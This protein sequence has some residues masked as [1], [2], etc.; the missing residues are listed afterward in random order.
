[1]MQKTNKPQVLQVALKIPFAPHLDYSLPNHLAL[2]P[3]G[4]RVLVGLG[5]NKIMVGV[6][7]SHSHESSFSSLKPIDDILDD[8]PLFNETGLKLLQQAATY[9]QTT[10]GEMIFTA[11][12]AWFKKTTNQ[13]I[14]MQKWWQAKQSLT[15]AKVLLKSAPKQLEVYQYLKLHGPLTSKSLS[16]ISAS[17]SQVC[18][19]LEAKNLASSTEL[20][21]IDNHSAIDPGYSLTTDQQ[22]ALTQ[23]SNHVNKFKVMLLDGITGSGKTELYIR[24]IQQLLQ[25]QK[26]ALVLVPEIGLTPQLF[27]EVSQRINGQMA[28]LH[29][30]LTDAAR[31]RVWHHCRTGMVDVVVATRSGIFTPFKN[32]GAILIDEEHDLS[33]KQQDGGIRYSARDLAVLRG[34]IEHIPVVLGSATPSFE[35]LNHAING[36]YH[37]LKLRSRTN[38]NPMPSILLQNAKN[39]LAKKGLSAKTLKAIQHHLSD[40]NQVLVF[41]NRR[42]WSPK[43]ICH[44]CSWV[45]SCD[46][47]D[48]YLTYHKHLNLLK[49]HHCDR[50]YGLPEFCPSCGSQHVETM[51]VGTEKIAD[52]LSELLPDTPVIRFDRDAVKT[53]AQW[54]KNLDVVRTGEPCVIVGT[55]MLSKGH[56]FPLLSLV[57]VVN[58]DNSFFSTDFRATEYLAQLLTQVSGRAGRAQTKGEVIIQ[59]QFPEQAFFQS[60]FEQGYEKFAEEQLQERADML[61]PPY[62]HMAII[63]AQHRDNNVLD[64]MLTEMAQ[65]CNNNEAVSVLGP[66][67]APIA[68]K[69]KYYRMQLILNANQRKALHQLIHQL[70]SQFKSSNT[71]LWHVDIDPVN[72]D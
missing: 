10:Y 40:G 45:A 39:N 4:A 3:V 63:R 69:Q 6:V 14:P 31:A 25:Q 18:L 55:Q 7:V 65:F 59:T 68:K 34:K 20:C 70:K 29:S 9:Y 61:F 58:V 28:V 26:Q 17:A 46:D 62:T 33:Y 24:F 57:V 2:P 47:C 23:L 30:G 44:E 71:F 21:L 64:Q 43:L 36:K 51:G 66:L 60:L 56:D 11:L 22:N 67:P 72:F 15:D 54:Q 38:N 41:L 50:R 35:T 49:C 48:V 32:L 27:Q 37:W 5:K 42:G 8:E 1:M 12:P 52:G 16:H 19:Q 13:P 53:P